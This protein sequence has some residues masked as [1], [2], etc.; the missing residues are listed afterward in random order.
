MATNLA[1]L[2]SARTAE[3]LQTELL[4][5]LV[6]EGF[7]TA[8]WQ[9]GSVPR[10]LVKGD[11]AALADLDTTVASL[12]GAAFLSTAEGLD[13]ADEEET[14]SWLDLLA[15]ERFEESR[16][17]ATFAEWTLTLAASASAGPYTLTAGALV[18]ATTGGVLFQSTNTTSVVVPL[19]GSVGITV[20]AR[21]KGT[22]GNATAPSV[23]VSP[24]L[25]GVSISAATLA[26]SAIDR[27]SDA[28]LIQRCRDKWATLAPAGAMQ[29][30]YRY[31][32]TTSGQGITRVA[33]ATPPGNGT[34]PAWVAGAS[35]LISAPQLVA[36]QAYV[37]ARKPMTDTPVISHATEVT[38]AVSGTVTFKAGQNTSANQSAVIDG[39]AAYF[40]GLE[41]SP[42]GADAVI[43]DEAGIKAAIYNAVP[44]KVKDAD[45]T[46]SSDTV[47]AAGEVAIRDTSGLGWA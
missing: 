28:A 41:I 1:D 18:V 26:T 44:G 34:V 15:E 5:E 36:A 46:P 38:I 4:A 19:G 7:P 25:A 47:L 27:E 37:T 6:A 14:A 9:E 12:A 20:K 23:V 21:R 33:F 40:A 2:I 39:I 43:V 31:W 45:I 8:D 16:I 24:A 17:Q 32:L 10:S 42:G 30:T 22:S 29:A 3:T 35:G 11:A 13:D